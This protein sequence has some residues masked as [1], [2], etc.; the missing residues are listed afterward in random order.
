M[1][2][3]SFIYLFIFFYL[4]LFHFLF[5]LI[6]S[7][8]HKV[9]YTYTEFSCRVKF[10]CIE[11]TIDIAIT[12]DVINA[13]DLLER[14]HDD[15]W[16]KKFHQYLES[17]DYNSNIMQLNSKINEFVSFSQYSLKSDF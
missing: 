14:G 4:I 13:K 15:F 11:F 17:V 10:I 8:Q 6:E 3:L 7:D 2:I 9:S 16:W 5:G 1:I 12:K